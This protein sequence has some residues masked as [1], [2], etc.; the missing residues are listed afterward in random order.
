MCTDNGAPRG[1]ITTRNDVLQHVTRIVADQL[2][3]PA[4]GLAESHALED[5]GCDSLDIVE[6]AMRLE[7]HF[8]IVIPDDFGESARTIGEVTDGVLQLLAAS[9]SH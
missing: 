3:R 8:D 2:G 6:I 1:G 5:L 7:E 4:D 9:A